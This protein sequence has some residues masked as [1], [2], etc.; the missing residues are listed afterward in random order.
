MRRGT[1]NPYDSNILKHVVDSMP[2]LFLDDIA[3]RLE[4]CTGKI[5]SYGYIWKRLK[6][7]TIHYK[8]NQIDLHNGMKNKEISSCKNLSIT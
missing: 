7:W 3:F 1:Y 4:V 8:W 5:W 6:K 2:Q